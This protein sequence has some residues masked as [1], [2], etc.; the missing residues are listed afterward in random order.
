MSF[1]SALDPL[2]SD[3][4]FGLTTLF[5][6]DPRSEKVNLSIGVYANDEGNTV[7]FEAIRQAEAQLNAEHPK[8]DYQS[9]E[10]NALLIN[11][12]LKL[13]F[14]ER[15]CDIPRDRFFGAQAIGG[16]G[17]L[18]LGAEFLSKMTSRTAYV[19]DPT[20]PIHN[21]LFNRAGMNVLP[22]PYYDNAEHRLSFA[23]MRNSIKRMAP[24]SVIVLHACCHNPTGIDPTEEQWKE[25]SVLI[26]RQRVIPFFD[27][28]YQG[29]GKGLEED[30]F[31]IRQFLRDG[32][33]LFISCSF[34]KNF[35]VYG[36][37]GGC[38]IA[39][40]KEPAITQTLGTHLKPTIRGLYSNP[41][42]TASRLVGK[43]LS[44]PELRSLWEQE[45]YE[46]RKR[47]QSTRKQFIEL[48]TEK[49][50]ETDFS[51]LSNQ[52]GM[53]SILGLTKP[54]VEQLRN[55]HA[56]FLPDNG[57]ISI[58]GLNQRNLQYVTD[59]IAK[60]LKK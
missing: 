2:P 1:F 18:R 37:R 54:L 9:I 21:L 45:L 14:G 52:Q 25:L 49:I 28:A 26:L 3:P 44:N 22:Y 48:L 19:S 43:V 30:V 31:P 29:F 32:H 39:L 33:E 50:P 59:S 60:V 53:F 7:V 35:G 42:L 6:Q 5:N 20:W 12:T 58:P 41:P 27:L 38:F 13:I 17:G 36:E 34:S 51:F 46:V 24:G 47:I 23:A 8:M 10:G 16:T 55:D 15:L 4:I 56:I 40:T 57:R 11:E